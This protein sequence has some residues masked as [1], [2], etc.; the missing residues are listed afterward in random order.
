MIVSE[1]R[2]VG[3]PGSVLSFESAPVHAPVDCTINASQ[4]GG[5][6]PLFPSCV[7][8]RAARRLQQAGEDSPD[9]NTTLFT[10]RPGAPRVVLVNLTM[11]GGVRVEGGDLNMINCVLDGNGLGPM[12]AMTI[13]AGVVELFESNIINYELG[14]ISVTGGALTVVR[15]NI[16][17]NGYDSNSTFGAIEVAGSSTAVVN[18]DDSHIEYNGRSSDDCTY[19]NVCVRGGGLYIAG[20][21]ALVN[22]GQGTVMR[23]NLAYEGD[24]IYVRDARALVGLR[25]ILPTPLGHYI[26]ITDRGNDATLGM[27]VVDSTYPFEC[28]PGMYGDNVTD[29]SSPRCSGRCTPGYYCPGATAR[30]IICTPGHHCELGSNVEADCPAGTFGPS[31]GLTSSSACLQCRAGMSCPQGSSVETPCP[32]GTYAPL[33][34][35][36]TCVPCEAG[37]Y[38]DVPG[39]TQCMICPTGHY[40][41]AGAAVLIPCPAGTYADIEGL[42]NESECE[43][44]IR[45]HYCLLGTSEPRPCDAGRVGRLEG[46]RDSSSCTQCITPTDSPAGSTTCDRCIAGAY[47]PPTN[48]RPHLFLTPDPHSLFIQGTTWTRTLR[49]PLHQRKPAGPVRALGLE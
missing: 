10:I 13:T 15:S 32:V 29:Q 34:G 47:T 6:S 14:G 31:F 22:M 3:A 17:R 38:Q 27:Q 25:Y 33:N 49:M 39:Q 11:R 41:P 8:P 18:L 36:V 1:I 42:R 2:L 48:P 43:T 4:T 20:L 45:G 44:C 19:P 24:Q 21:Q 16:R 46:L 28:A 30:P 26:I 7:V 9:L 5:Y 40:C 35:T 37:T 23:H 12:T